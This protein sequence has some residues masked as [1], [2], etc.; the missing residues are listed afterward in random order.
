MAGFLFSD[1][2]FGPVNSRRLGV[3]L[4]INLLPTDYKFCTFN[5]VYCECGWTK[6]GD[7]NK[8]PLPSTGE[9][10]EKL[11]AK[12]KDLADQGI[13]PDAITFAG[14]GEPTL[15][16]E[17]PDIM[18]MVI[19][20]RDKYFPDARITVLSNASQVHKEKIF[21]ALR[22]ADQ[23]ILK[24]DAGTDE[25]F[26]KINQ[27]K[28]NL[29]I[30]DVVDSLKKFEGKL[31]IQT[32]FMEGTINGQKVSNT[33]QEEIGK[34]IEHLREI[35]PE[36]VMIYAIDRETPAENI[37]K[38]SFRELNEIADKVELAGFRTKVFG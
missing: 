5:C 1:M 21:M 27:P 35:N 26:R 12:M 14:N 24:L 7:G 29:T 22:K 23:N 3:S 10:R 17:F 31:I 9:L 4:G 15:H 2:V 13:L 33:G 19:T 25:T 16:P 37:R 38:L 11:E 34:W 36:Y 32:L 28:G 30:R 20:L 8:F 18:D 6:S